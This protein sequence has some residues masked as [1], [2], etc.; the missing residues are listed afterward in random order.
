[1]EKSLQHLAADKILEYPIDILEY[2][3]EKGRERIKNKNK[4]EVIVK[5]HI[6]KLMDLLNGGKEDYLELLNFFIDMKIDDYSDLPN[7]LFPIDENQL[8]REDLCDIKNSLEHDLISVE[9]ISYD[10]LSE[11]LNHFLLF[12]IYPKKNKELIDLLYQYPLY[13]KYFKIVDCYKYDYA[14]I[15]LEKNRYGEYKYKGHEIGESINEM[16][17]TDFTHI[18]CVFQIL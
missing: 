3:V 16:T 9:E 1:M 7:Y 17:I 4:R 15:S 2:I 18:S 10:D 6:D 14:C 12:C 13:I 8:E 11:I 5:I